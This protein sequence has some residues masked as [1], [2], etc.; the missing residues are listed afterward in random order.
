MKDKLLNKKEAI[1]ILKNHLSKNVENSNVT[2]CNI[3]SSKPEWWF[4]VSNKKFNSDLHL[5]LNNHRER[6][7]YYFFI[8]SSSIKNPYVLF[9][10]DSGKNDESNMHI[11]VDDEYFADRKEKYQ[12]LKYLKDKINY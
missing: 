7:L 9:Y 10:Q 6:I 4:H 12:F 2:F 11:P 8:K 5:L 1:G 3:C